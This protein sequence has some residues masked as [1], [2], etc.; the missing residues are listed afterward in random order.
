M[1][2]SWQL[3]WTGVVIWV[4]SLIQRRSS[5]TLNRL[6]STLSA[7]PSDLMFKAEVAFI[8]SPRVRGAKCSSWDWWHCIALMTAWSCSAGCSTALP[9]SDVSEGLNYLKE[10]T[11]KDLEPLSH[12]LLWFHL[13]LRNV[14]P[15]PA[16]NRS[17]WYHS[18]KEDAQD[19]TNVPTWTV[20]RSWGHN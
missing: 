2:I 20:E 10:H 17:G 13:R 14:S 19:L 6:P 7:I 16:P 18:A 15:N 9:V 3:Y 8:I 12:R 1:K 5:L 11:P 4:F